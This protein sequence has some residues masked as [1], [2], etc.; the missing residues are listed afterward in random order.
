MNALQD[1][2]CGMQ[3]GDS[4]LRAEGYDNVGFCSE[5]CRR[6]FLAD[7]ARY[8]AKAV[9][10]PGSASAPEGEGDAR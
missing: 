9:S 10:A 4:A 5:H 3:V 2:V 7:P 1:P 6:A 8:W